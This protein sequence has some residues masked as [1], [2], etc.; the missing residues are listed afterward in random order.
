M[1]SL[2]WR[3]ELLGGRVVAR[4]AGGFLTRRNMHTLG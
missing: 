1:G 2:G 4:V 3:L